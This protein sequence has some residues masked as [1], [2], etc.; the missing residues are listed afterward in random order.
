MYPTNSGQMITFS[1]TFDW[2]IYSNQ[3]FDDQISR[4]SHWGCLRMKM[5]TSNQLIIICRVWCWVIVTLSVGCSGLLLENILRPWRLHTLN[6]WAHQKSCWS[7]VQWTQFTAGIS[8]FSVSRH[9][10]TT[11]ISWFEKL[12]INQRGCSIACGYMSKSFLKQRQKHH[13]SQQAIPR[14]SPHHAEFSHHFQCTQVHHFDFFALLSGPI[15]IQI[16]Y[17]L[18]GYIPSNP[19]KITIFA[20]RPTVPT[21]AFLALEGR[22]QTVTRPS[23]A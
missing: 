1:Q 18:V 4:F 3:R 6:P 22:T 5:P 16:S 9:G 19:I 12:N 20:T 2:I 14:I 21:G 23:P 17:W 8:I 7:H 10:T 11:F 15:L 13:R